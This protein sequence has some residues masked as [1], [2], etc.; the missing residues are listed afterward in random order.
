MN[1]T[2]VVAAIALSYASAKAAPEW[3]LSPQG[4]GPVTIGMT[5]VEAAEALGTPL[6]YEGEE[7]PDPACHHLLAQGRND[8]LRYMVQEGRIVRIS[9]YEGPSTVPTD[10]GIRLGDPASRIMDAYGEELE[11]ETHEYVKGKYFTSW[12]ER[13]KRGIRYETM[14]DEPGPFIAQGDTL[15]FRIHAGDESIHLIEGCS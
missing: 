3:P 8:K 5:P 10:K 9:L 2:I 14:T 4:Y 12:D 1:R 11:I 13:T 7:A 6:R 15:V